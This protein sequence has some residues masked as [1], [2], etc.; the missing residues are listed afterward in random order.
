[1]SVHAYSS[2]TGTWSRNQTDEE[3]EEGQL[4]AWRQ[5]R[6]NLGDPNPRCP[7]VNGF[8]HL[9]VWDDDEMKLVALDVQGKSRR[10]I[11][12]PHVAEAG[13]C[14]CYFG[15]SQGKLH[16]MTQEVVGDAAEGKYKLSVWVS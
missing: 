5:V 10:M 1:M 2:E 9:P 3:E 8:L 4:E 15:E 13:C 12:V 6:F 14:M 7:F 11:Q 16:Y